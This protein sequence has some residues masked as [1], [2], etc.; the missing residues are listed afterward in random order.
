M[1]AQRWALGGIG[2]D[3][4]RIRPDSVA[5]TSESGWFRLG[6]AGYVDAEGYVFLTDRIK[7]MIVSGVPDARWGETVKD[8]RIN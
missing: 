4:A 2:R 5:L 1:A 3:H 6:D 8:R 7:D